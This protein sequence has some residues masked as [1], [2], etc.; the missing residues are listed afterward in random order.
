LCYLGQ[1]QVPGH[2]LVL[3]SSGLAEIMGWILLIIAVIIECFIDLAQLKCML[4]GT[5]VFTHSGLSLASLNAAISLLSG[6]R[7]DTQLRDII[8]DI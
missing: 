1:Q 7:F 8:S 3:R 6:S 2:V 5:R 4:A